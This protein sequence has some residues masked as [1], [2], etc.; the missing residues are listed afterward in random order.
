MRA[1]QL[2]CVFDDKPIGELTDLILTFC[3][4]S[5]IFQVSSE[6]ELNLQRL[7]I[8]SVILLIRNPFYPKFV[9]LVPTSRLC[10]CGSDLI[11]AR[12]FSGSQSAKKTDGR[13]EQ[14]KQPKLHKSQGK[15]SLIT[16]FLPLYDQGSSK[17]APNCCRIRF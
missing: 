2:L 5:A 9:L 3:I 17:L 11:K 8:P 15:L 13:Q 10:E 12:T 1:R 6:I 14:E 7:G 4:L 16:T